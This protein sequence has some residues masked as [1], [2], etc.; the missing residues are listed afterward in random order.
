VSE[1]DKASTHQNAPTR[2]LE[3]VYTLVEKDDP[4]AAIDVLF[5]HIDD[6]LIACEFEKCDR[7]LRSIDVKRLD[8]NLMIATLGITRSAAARLNERKGLVE[9]VESKLRDDALAEVDRL[10]KNLRGPP[11]T[12][13]QE[14]SERMSGSMYT[15]FFVDGYSVVVQPDEDGEHLLVEAEAY[16]ADGRGYGSFQLRLNHERVKQIRSVMDRWALQQRQKEKEREAEDCSECGGRRYVEYPP[17]VGGGG[18][19]PKCNPKE[20]NREAT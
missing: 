16:D 2:W 4:D 9:R 14:G 15:S 19:C 7:V 6:L 10:L 20:P 11:E 3:E 17:P 8:R 12:R 13:P 1:R 18:P 5:D